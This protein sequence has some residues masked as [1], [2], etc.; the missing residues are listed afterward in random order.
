MNERHVVGADG[1]RGL[2]CV[3]VLALHTIVISFPD[4]FPYVVGCPKIGVWLFFVLSSFLLTYQL[5]KRGFNW[6]SLADYGVG[7]FLRII[8]A[9]AVVVVLYRIFG[10]AGINTW[11][12]VW[13]A[14]TFQHGYVH[15]WTIPVEFKAYA[16][17]PFLP[18]LSSGFAPLSAR[19][20]S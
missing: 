13:L 11:N 15:L 3:I 6:R 2:A 10:T 19:S 4:T 18:P 16:L 8:P 5:E 14:L 7:R 12:D 9:F 17:I 1:I 20:V